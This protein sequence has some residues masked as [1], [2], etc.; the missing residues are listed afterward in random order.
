MWIIMYINA[1]INI[2]RYTCDVMYYIIFKFRYINLY[3]VYSINTSIVLPCVAEENLC[4]C[5]SESLYDR[6][7]LL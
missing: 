4:M 2:L 7:P 5:S 1:I 3:T 6:V